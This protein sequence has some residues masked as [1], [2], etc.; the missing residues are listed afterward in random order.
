[1]KITGGTTEALALI[2]KL[3]ASGHLI[4]VYSK[5][6]MT[7]ANNTTFNAK[8][9]DVLVKKYSDDFAHHL[10]V[11]SVEKYNDEINGLFIKI[12]PRLEKVL[13]GYVH[14]PNFL[15]I[16]L[17]T[18]QLL[19]VGLGRKNN[20]FAIPL[21][22][23]ISLDM[24]DL[25]EN[26]YI[27]KFTSLDHKNVLTEICKSVADL[28]ICFC[29]HEDFFISQDDDLSEDE[30]NEIDDQVAALF[31]KQEKLTNLIKN[32]FPDFDETEINTGDY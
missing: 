19:A 22:E 30:Q 11:V 29:E 15:F 31:E 8:E 2:K 23:D 18:Q 5:E 25:F 10:L 12:Y 21:D 16:N 17:F 4:D 13:S 6:W 14:R 26:S 9:F 1:M 20:L 7:K 32:Y 3:K 27:K 24:S 28:G